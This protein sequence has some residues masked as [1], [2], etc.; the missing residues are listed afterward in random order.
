MNRLKV[1]RCGRGPLKPQPEPSV[2]LKTAYQG[3]RVGQV[4][5]E[6]GEVGPPEGREAMAFGS[7]PGAV[8]LKARDNSGGVDAVE[9][10]NYGVEQSCVHSAVTSL[11][12]RTSSI[13]RSIARRYRGGHGG[14]P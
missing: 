10:T 11:H 1:L 9:E 4:E 8:L 5:D 14:A 3:V 13:H 7:A 6:A 12:Y 2:V